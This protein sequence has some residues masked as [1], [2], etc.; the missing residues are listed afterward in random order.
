MAAG[1]FWDRTADKYAATPIADEA[2]YQTKLAETRRR[3]RKDMKLFEFGCGTGSTALVHAPYV[4]HIR[5]IDASARM[6]EIAQGKAKAAGI[7]NVSFEQGD[8]DQIALESG[9]FDMVLAMSVLHLLEDKARAI[10]TVYRILKPGGYFVSSTAC[11]REMIPLF[12]L[13]VP[14]GKRLGLMPHVDVM[15]TSQ[16]I[17]EIERPGFTIEHQWRPKRMAA[18]FVIARKPGNSSNHAPLPVNP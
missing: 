12:S 10:R 11:V 2:S 16:L 17:A 5:G 13:V 6:I 7:D 8:I 4:A 14:I 18:H 9:S 3:L 1:E 15:R